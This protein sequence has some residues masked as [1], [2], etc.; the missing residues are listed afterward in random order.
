M[1]KSC[2]GESHQS[3]TIFI[4]DNRRLLHKKL[5]KNCS[6]NGRCN[7]ETYVARDLA[8]G[9]GSELGEGASRIGAFAEEM[10][11]PVAQRRQIVFGFDL[12]LREGHVSQWQGGIRYGV[13]A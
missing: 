11:C 9:D 7:V 13:T 4:V 8:S 10:L 5:S 6:Y 3:A 12:A 2:L 1:E